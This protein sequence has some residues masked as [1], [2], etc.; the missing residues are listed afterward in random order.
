MC[1][2]PE[3]PVAQAQ[4]HVVHSVEEDDTYKKVLQNNLRRRQ[5]WAPK[6]G[7]LH[8]IVGDKSEQQKTV[9]DY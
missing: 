3:R 5:A 9:N 6:P 4:N 2:L 7:L 8:M 1:C